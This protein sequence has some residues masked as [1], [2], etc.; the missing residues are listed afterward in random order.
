[1]MRGTSR[2]CG[3]ICE[4]PS[5]EI[6][7]GKSASV[8]RGRRGRPRPHLEPNL[9]TLFGL[10]H[11]YGTGLIRPKWLWP[12]AGRPYFR[13]QGRAVHASVKRTKQPDR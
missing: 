7:A 8:Q 6:G 9:G 12:H 11:S 3:S 4:T 10:I 5:T 1:M 2:D 13:S